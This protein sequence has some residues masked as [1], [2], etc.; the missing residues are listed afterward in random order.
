MPTD[1]GGGAGAGIAQTIEE[2]GRA[3]ANQALAQGN[4]WGG[5][6]ANLGQLVMQQP[7][8]QALE[9]ERKARAMDLQ[10]QAEIRQQQML[11]HQRDQEGSQALAKAIG[12]PAN[13]GDPER[14]YQAVSAAGY[15][16]AGQ[17]YL[18][19][20]TDHS[21]AL[22]KLRANKEA[23]QQQVAN[24]FDGAD[25]TDTEGLRARLGLL[26]SQGV[27][28]SP[29]ADLFDK[30]GPDAA[31]RQIVDSAP[32]N[33]KA[34]RAATAEAAKE[35]AKGPKTREIRT[36]N[37]DGSESV[38]I[39]EDKPNQS[40]T[41]SAPPAPE[42][43]LQSENVLLDGKP[44]MVTFNPKTGRR[45]NAAGEDVS[46]RVKPLPP[47]SVIYPKPEAPAG[48]S[49]SDLT[50]EGVEYAATQYRVTGQMP[51]LGMGKTPARAQIINKA[52]EQARI[53]GQTPAAAIQKQAA[54]KADGSALK[55]MQELSAGAEAAENKAIGQIDLIK[56][57]STKVPRT[58]IPLIN[59]AIL[60]G[61]INVLGDS[62]AQQLAN[63]I[64]TF[65]NEYG[66]I[67]EGSTASVAG[68]SE[69]AR[70]AS[71][72]LVSA[73]M[74][75][76]TLDDVLTLMQKEMDLTLGGYGAT[77]DHITTR[78]GGT[79]AAQ[80]APSNAPAAPAGGMPLTYQDYLK[81]KGGK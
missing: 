13:Q 4:I 3:R 70:K 7:A 15:P 80:P 51:S 46:D 24:M 59:S 29:Y 55:R 2:L 63:A 14:V 69:S 79:P 27:D 8:R 40:F 48:S 44:A 39:V 34:K 17:K 41:S 37:A 20:A 76:K 52:A 43:S 38:Q 57:L 26:H 47:A 77:I 65:S 16:E 68:A 53:L 60:N 18:K 11:A 6:L 1:W 71:G 58:Q 78:M 28:V 23:E 62:N 30:V 10:Q 19:L 36:R 54:F 45:F 5:T 73:S 22:G 75:P 35:A 74:N 81:S 25:P 32:E 56:D 64:Q 12:D 49:P 50:P 72:K 61:K 31:I 33:V 21:E 67:I 42:P 9:D 66:K